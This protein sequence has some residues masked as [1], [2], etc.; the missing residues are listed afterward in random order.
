MTVIAFDGSTLAADKQTCYGPLIRTTTKIHRVGDLL[1]GCAGDTATSV[2]FVEWV[3][4]GRRADDFPKKQLDD[5]TSVSAVVIEADGSISS[6]DTAPYPIRIED[7]QFAI[8]SGRDFALAAMHLGL[9]AHDAV[10]VAAV[11][12]NTCGNGV[13]TL[14]LRSLQ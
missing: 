2:E 10:E 6:Y 3:R 8:G 11:F 5:K 14:Q 12:D 1:V 13:D 4:R 7:D 9:S